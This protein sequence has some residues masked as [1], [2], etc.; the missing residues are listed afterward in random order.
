M[1]V[2]LR[3]VVVLHADHVL[4]HDAQE[5]RVPRERIVGMTPQPGMAQVVAAE[6][7]KKS[8]YVSL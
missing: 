3:E 7:G 6:G 1:V 2:R 8:I 4:V 5:G